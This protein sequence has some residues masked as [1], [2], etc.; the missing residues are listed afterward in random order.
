MCNRQQKTNA[1]SWTAACLSTTNKTLFP[2]SFTVFL[3]AFLSFSS[4][5]ED[6]ILALRIQSDGLVFRNAVS[7]SNGSERRQCQAHF[8]E[9]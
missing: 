5:S 1:F 7:F 2:F 4:F 3:S 8:G 9:L 6:F